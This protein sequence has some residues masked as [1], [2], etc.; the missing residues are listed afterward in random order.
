[1]IWGWWSAYEKN[2]VCG[3]VYELHTKSLPDGKTKLTRKF[4]STTPGY[5]AS[6]SK[7]QSVIALCKD[8]K[9]SYRVTGQMTPAASKHKDAANRLRAARKKAIFTKELERVTTLRA[10]GVDPEVHMS[11]VSKYVGESRSSLYRKLGKSFPAPTKRGRA[12][13]WSMSK[14]EAY[15]GDSHA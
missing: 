5:R 7:D 10:A 6:A 14:V 2:L 15:M 4:L 11:F 3:T 13:F 8:T 9:I 12:S 1:M